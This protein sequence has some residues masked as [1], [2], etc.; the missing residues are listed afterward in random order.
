MQS[1]AFQIQGVQCW[2]WP[3]TLQHIAQRLHSPEVGPTKSEIV[4]RNIELL[5][6]GLALSARFQQ[7][8]QATEIRF[9][10]GTDHCSVAEIHRHELAYRHLTGNPMSPCWPELSIINW[11]ELHAPSKLAGI[12][13][14]VAPAAVAAARHQRGQRR[15]IGLFFLSFKLFADVRAAMLAS[16]L[17]RCSC[18]TLRASSFSTTARSI[19]R[20]YN[21]L[22]VKSTASRKEIKIAYLKL[23]QREHPDKNPGAKRQ[24]AS[25][26]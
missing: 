25:C 7:E 23:A 13:S 22:G 20:H 8:V 14:T 10:A 1:I 17:R 19:S 9:L 3:I 21:L 15:H 4:Q 2:P 5:Q 12:R 11:S 24:T 18:S 16:G 26:L 6:L